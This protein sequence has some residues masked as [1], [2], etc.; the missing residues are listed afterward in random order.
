MGRCT[1]SG[2][3]KGVTRMDN[4]QLA[5]V[6]KILGISEDSISAMDDEIKNSMT[7]VF[8]Q[9]AVKND[10]DKKAVFEALDNLWQKGSIYIELSEVANSTGITIE[11]LRSLD[12]ETQQTIVYEFLMDSSQTA[13]FYDLVNKALAVADLPNV[14]KLTGISMNELRKLPRRVQENICGAYAMEYDPDST[15]ADLIAALREMIEP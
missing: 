1:I 5:E 11:T 15:N 4:K 13:R 10:E 14:A 12:Y 3:Q 8:E 6:A 9:V 2:K 7:V